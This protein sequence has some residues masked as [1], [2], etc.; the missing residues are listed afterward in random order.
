[1]VRSQARP[2]FILAQAV[3]FL[4]KRKTEIPTLHNLNESILGE[5][6]RHKSSLTKCIDD[7]LAPSTRKLLDELFDRVESISIE[8]PKLQRY[9]WVFSNKGT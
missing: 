7:G 4:E 2:K 9:R 5:I 8:E 3:E 6:K 1:M